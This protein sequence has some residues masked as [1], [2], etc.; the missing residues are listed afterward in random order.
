MFIYH[1]AVVQFLPSWQ[2]SFHFFGAHLPPLFPSRL[3]TVDK[4]AASE[5]RRQKIKNINFEELPVPVP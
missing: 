5:Q 2:K 4:D 3:A 1:T